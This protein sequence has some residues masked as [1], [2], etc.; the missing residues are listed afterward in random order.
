MAWHIDQLVL[1]RLDQ[2]ISNTGGKNGRRK[3]YNVTSVEETPGQ[4]QIGDTANTTF[5]NQGTATAIILGNIIL[6][7]GQGIAFPV[8]EGEQDVTKYTYTFSGAGTRSLL[9]IQRLYTDE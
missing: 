2:V 8:N 6:A 5:F 9:I 3:T 4:L 7:Q 1:D